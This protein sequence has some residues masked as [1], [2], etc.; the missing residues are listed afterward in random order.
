MDIDEV[1]G[2]QPNVTGASSS[3]AAGV[4]RQSSM[5]SAEARVPPKDPTEEE[6]EAY[7][8]V[9]ERWAVEAV[10]WDLLLQADWLFKVPATDE[11]KKDMERIAELTKEYVETF[12]NGLLVAMLRDKAKF[13]RSMKAW[14]CECHWHL[15]ALQKKGWLP[16]NLYYPHDRHIR[17]EAGACDLQDFGNDTWDVVCHVLRLPLYCSEATRHR[18]VA[19]ATGQYGSS[20]EHSAKGKVN[21]RGSIIGDMCRSLQDMGTHFDA[22]D[23]VRRFLW[24]LEKK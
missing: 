4:S 15:N 24:R 13:P 8:K 10:H 1:G 18:V 9:I 23:H 21:L 3:S 6:K 11:N 14:L 17:I 22:E 19:I 20:S 16:K 7:E 12:D 5:G 2:A